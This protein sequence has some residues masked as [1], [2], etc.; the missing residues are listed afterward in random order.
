VIHW[1]LQTGGLVKFVRSFGLTL[2]PMKSC[3][4]T[5]NTKNGI[6]DHIVAM[7]VDQTYTEEGILCHRVTS[8]ESLWAIKDDPEAREE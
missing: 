7:E 6:A 1:Y 5:H 2:S 3:G 8:L 4:R